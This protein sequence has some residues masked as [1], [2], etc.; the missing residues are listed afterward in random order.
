MARDGHRAKEREKMEAQ[1]RLLRVGGAPTIVRRLADQSW[2]DALEFQR[3]RH[4]HAPEDVDARRVRWLTDPL[5][6]ASAIEA[7]H[8]EW[9]RR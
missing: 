6:L 4:L 7:W 5:T 1:Y 2:D 3:V 8:A 9:S